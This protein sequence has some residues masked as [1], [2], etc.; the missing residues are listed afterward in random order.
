MASSTP[1]FE[2]P[3]A[4]FTILLVLQDKELTMREIHDALVESGR[5]TALTTV[6]TQVRV[7]RSKRVIDVSPRT[8]GNAKVFRCV[9]GR[10]SQ[11]L[12]R[13]KLDHLLSAIYGFN[14]V[15]LVQDLLE[16]AH[17][18][19]RELL[20]LRQEVIRRKRVLSRQA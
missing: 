15:L 4:Q 20:D 16:L 11:T 2:I 14:T 6:R 19:G 17:F 9:A 13:K 1:W 10:D 5:K 7:L 3:P 18:Q 12:R 8:K